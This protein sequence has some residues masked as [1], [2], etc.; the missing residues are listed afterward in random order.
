MNNAETAEEKQ[1]PLS[2]AD[3]VAL[4]FEENFADEFVDLPLKN[5]IFV[6]TPLMF[7]QLCLL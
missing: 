2:G 3:F 7:S 6:K 5:Y 4:F 1:D